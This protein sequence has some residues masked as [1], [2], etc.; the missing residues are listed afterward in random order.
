MIYMW[1]NAAAL[2]AC[3]WCFCMVGQALAASR[4]IADF[5]IPNA[6]GPFY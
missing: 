5:S 4:I 3:R 1:K 2:M 6:T